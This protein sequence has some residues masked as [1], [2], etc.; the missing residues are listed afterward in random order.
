MSSSEISLELRCDNPAAELLVV[1]SDFKIIKKGSSPLTATVAPGIYSLKAKI[2]AQFTEKLMMV[3]GEQDAQQVRLIAPEFE[4]P[5]PLRDTRT[6]REYHE[7]SLDQFTGS[8][9]TH[10]TLGE[11]SAI[12]LY[13]R[14]TSRLN[15]N[16]KEEEA[17]A[18]ADNFKGFR[19]LDGQG[20]ELVNF[21]DEGKST[22]HPLEGYMG[23][24]VGVAPGHYV[25]SW[26][27][28]GR[29]TRLSLNTAHAWTLQVFLRLQLSK[30]GPVA[31][32]P[33]FAEAAFAYETIGMAYSAQSDDSRMLEAAR[34]A[35]L[36]RRNV[37]SGD[38]MRD[39]LTGRE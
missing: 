23:A 15:F 25:L 34:L 26:K 2:G 22:R 14:D 37:V 29:E 39:I 7:G 24:R 18:Y 6:S 19:L 38:M 36:D 4:S 31:M 32:V 30:D 27:R 16:R 21:D 9:A 20:Q 35:L 1:D 12:V 5:M 3:D 10:A 8:G 33:D 11:G 28:S 17:A 13:V